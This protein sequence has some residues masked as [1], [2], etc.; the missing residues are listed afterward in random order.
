VPEA[1]GKAWKTLGEGFT[2]CDTRQKRL[3]ELYIS[4]DFF[5]PNTFYQALDKDFAECHS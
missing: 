4:N 1:L 2:E 3:G 5:L